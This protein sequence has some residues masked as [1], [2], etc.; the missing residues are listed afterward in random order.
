MTLK[1]QALEYEELAKL[2]KDALSDNLS[3]GAVIGYTTNGTKVTYSTQ[4]KLRESLLEF[5]RLAAH[6]NAQIAQMK[7]LGYSV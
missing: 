2:T 1:E 7:F 6:A 4:E 5:R 3:A